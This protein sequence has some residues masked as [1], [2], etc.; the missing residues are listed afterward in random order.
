MMPLE[1]EHMAFREDEIRVLGRASSATWGIGGPLAEMQSDRP[2]SG[3]SR[4]Q[5]KGTWFR[6]LCE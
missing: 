1:F 4:S 3:I 5:E 6:V 2:D